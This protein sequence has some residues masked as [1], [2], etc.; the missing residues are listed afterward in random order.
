MDQRGL[1]KKN[2]VTVCGIRESKRCFLLRT[3]QKEQRGDDFL[4]KI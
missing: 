1:K 4:P 2:E 3:L